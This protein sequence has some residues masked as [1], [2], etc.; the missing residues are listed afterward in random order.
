MVDHGGY[1]TY[2]AHL[3]RFAVVPGQE[4]RQGEVVGALGASGRVTA[5]HLHY[6]VRRNGNALN[7]SAFL[8]RRQLAQIVRA[9]FPF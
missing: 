8:G 7:P 1:Q 2:Y 3:A 5:A 4:I 9:D 6:E